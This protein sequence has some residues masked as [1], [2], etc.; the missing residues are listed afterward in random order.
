MKLEEKIRQI[1]KNTETGEEEDESSTPG[2]DQGTLPVQSNILPGKRAYE[3]TLQEGSIAHCYT[4]PSM[5]D[6]GGRKEKIAE[7]MELRKRRRQDDMQLEESPMKR[8]RSREGEDQGTGT[9]EDKKGN[10]IKKR[11]H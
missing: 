4:G 9:R 7:K 3:E 2:T 10:L 11:K 1:R 5:A 6:L 8:R